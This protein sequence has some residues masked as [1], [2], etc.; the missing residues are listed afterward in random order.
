MGDILSAVSDGVDEIGERIAQ[1]V[2]SYFSDEKNRT[3][4]NRLKEQGLRM[5]VSEEQLANRS[6]K[7]KGLTIVISGTFSKH[8]VTSIRR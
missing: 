8:H 3:L 4:V 6:E 5:A 2:L 1:S 7:L